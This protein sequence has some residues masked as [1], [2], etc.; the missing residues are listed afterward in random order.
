AQN[1]VTLSALFPADEHGPVPKV[2]FHQRTRSARTLAN[3]EFLAKQAAELARAAGATKVFRLSW[4]PLILHV[5]S[6]MRMGLDEANSVLDASAE[7]RAVNR[8]FIGDNAAL[9]NGLGGPNPTL[10]SPAAA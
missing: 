3:R 5:Q 1:R 8:L 9:P 7:S 10:T 4:P 6:S 2:T